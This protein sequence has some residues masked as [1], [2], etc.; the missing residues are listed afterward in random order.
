MPSK[1][2][3][4]RSDQDMSIDRLPKESPKSCSGILATTEGVAFGWRH[5]RTYNCHELEGLQISISEALL[6]PRASGKDEQVIC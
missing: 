5:A 2:S 6:M 3:H 4:V 1:V